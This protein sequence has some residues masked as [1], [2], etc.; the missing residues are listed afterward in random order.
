NQDVASGKM[1]KNFNDWLEIFKQEK[2]AAIFVDSF[3][4]RNITDFCDVNPPASLVAAAEFVRPTDA[5]SALNYL[6]R[7]KE[8]IPNK[9]ALLGFSHGAT[10][11]LSTIVDADK[12]AKT[13]WSV[14][15][16]GSTYPAESPAKKPN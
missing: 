1:Q 6:K 3:S 2:Y 12:V 9:I 4:A 7:N 10:T 15:Y 11:T 13:T 16:E 5:Y 14:K 8:I